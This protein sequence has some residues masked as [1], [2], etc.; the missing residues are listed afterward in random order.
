M[1]CP[2]A[3]VFVDP[4]LLLPPLLSPLS[5]SS[6]FFLPHETHHSPLQPFPPILVGSFFNALARWCV[7]VFVFVFA[8]FAYLAQAGVGDICT[9]IHASRMSKLPPKKHDE[10]LEFVV[11]PKR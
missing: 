4:L 10:P 8:C 1:L 2:I 3:F 9:Y 11:L 6:R 5:S 7:S